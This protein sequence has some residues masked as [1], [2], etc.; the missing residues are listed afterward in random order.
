MRHPSYIQWDYA[1]RKHEIYSY[2][3]K[4]YKSTWEK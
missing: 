4:E 2:V 1:Y 3:E